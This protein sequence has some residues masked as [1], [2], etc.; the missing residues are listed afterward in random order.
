L[1]MGPRNNYLKEMI[2]RLPHDM[3]IWCY[4]LTKKT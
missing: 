1:E 4:L 2:S 3:E